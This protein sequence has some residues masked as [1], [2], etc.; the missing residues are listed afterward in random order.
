[1]KILVHVEGP[2][3][4]D[5]LGKLLF[6]LV[7]EGAKKHIGIRF[8]PLGGKVEVLDKGP[9]KA[10]SHLAE[11]PTDWVFLLP[12]LYPMSKFDGTANAHRS[13]EELRQLLTKR[14]QSHPDHARIPKGARSHFRVHCLKH[15]LEALLLAAPSALS[16]RLRTEDAMRGRW[17]IPVEDQDDQEPPKK[18]VADLFRQYSRQ[19][20]TDT[21]DA[22]WI[23]ERAKLEEIVQACPQQFAPLV[24]DLRTA[25]GIAG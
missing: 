18:V 4:R 12:D 3:D 24:Q 2:S 19:R 8:L 20:Y 10:A 7:S 14:F 17:R 6:S 22:P 1:V 21:V 15:D 16:K 25:L 23:L 11:H 9:M 5:G 13:F